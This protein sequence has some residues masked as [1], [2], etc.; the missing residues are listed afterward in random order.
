MMFSQDLDPAL[1]A[2]LDAGLDSQGI[3]VPRRLPVTTASFE[4]AEAI[5]KQL[6]AGVDAVIGFGG[7]KA[8]D[9]AKYVA[10]L[11]G[12]PYLAVPTS[13]SNENATCIG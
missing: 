4:Q 5:F 2:R 12:L 7:G 8:L 11:S 3:T 6:P 10:F 9:V 1:L 13:L